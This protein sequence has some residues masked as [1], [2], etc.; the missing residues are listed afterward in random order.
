MCGLRHQLSD[1]KP[2]FYAGL[3]S[4]ATAAEAARFLENHRT[5]RAAL[6]SMRDD[7]AVRLWLDRA[8]PETHE[9]IDALRA[10]I[11]T[12][13]RSRLPHGG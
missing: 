13:G 3:F 12:V 1:P 4:M 2:W 10:G 9:L 11:Q 7:E 8:G 5:T 6:P